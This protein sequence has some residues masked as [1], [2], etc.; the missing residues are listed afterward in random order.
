[1]SIKS[2]VEKL[3]SALIAR[4][5]YQTKYFSD[6]PREVYLALIKDNPYKRKNENASQVIALDPTEAY[7]RMKDMTRIHHE[8]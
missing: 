8:S 2:R 5:N 1:M 3:E 6:N 4:A 7:Q